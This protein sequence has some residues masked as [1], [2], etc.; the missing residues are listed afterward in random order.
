VHITK[1]ERPSRPLFRAR[2]QVGIFYS[3]FL[4]QEKLT[5]RSVHRSLAMSRPSETSASAFCMH[6][7]MFHF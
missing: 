3:V 2:T 1:F 7:A 4:A 5:G 6:P